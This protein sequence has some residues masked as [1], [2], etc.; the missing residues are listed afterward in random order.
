MALSEKQENA[1]MVFRTGM[2]CAQAVLSPF[3]S[4]ENTMT[5]L[6]IATGFG[7]GMGRLQKTCGAATGAYMA[8]GLHTAKK[9]DVLK[10]QKDETARHIRT[11]NELFL[12]RFGTDQCSQLLN[13]NLRTEEGQQAF[14]DLQLS[15]KVCEKCVAFAVNTVEMLNH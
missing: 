2:N 7:G 10:E 1:L 3:C 6:Q 12:A 15:E 13:V 5:V 4:P 14:K 8:I 9:Y 11:F